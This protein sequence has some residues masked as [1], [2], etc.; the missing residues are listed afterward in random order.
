[1]SEVGR[2]VLHYCAMMDGGSESVAGPEASM[3]PVVLALLAIIKELIQGARGL[4][5]DEEARHEEALKSRSR[6]PPAHPEC[7]QPETLSI[8]LSCR[9]M[10]QDNLPDI[11]ANELLDLG[12]LLDPTAVA[13]EIA[14]RKARSS[15]V[16]T[17]AITNEKNTTGE[18]SQADAQQYAP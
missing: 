2:H 7:G 16:G 13:G 4:G 17:Q 14:E 5:I 3:Y 11:L 15:V 9:Y 10:R 1:M 8:K 12:Y 6:V 18:D